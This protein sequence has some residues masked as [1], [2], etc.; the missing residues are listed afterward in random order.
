MNKD[1]LVAA[2]IRFFWATVFP[3]LGAGV[4]YLTVPENVESVG[5]TNVLAA[6]LIAGLA[7]GAKKLFF[8]DTKF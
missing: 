2:I 7:Y 6:S 5:I 4:M 3:L 8:P 1:T